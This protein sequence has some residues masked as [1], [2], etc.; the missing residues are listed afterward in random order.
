MISLK[1]CCARLLFTFSSLIL[2]AACGRAGSEDTAPALPDADA[3][4]AEL[5]QSADIVTTELTVRKLAI[6][7][8]EKSEPFTWTQPRTW[9]YGEQKCIIPVE[10]RIK[11]GYDLH[12]LSIDDIRL[13]PDSSS[14]VITLPAPKIIDASYNTYIDRGSVVGMSSG[15]RS[16]IG[17]AL[18]EEIRRKGYEAVLAEDL[19]PTVGRDIEQNAR[20]LFTSIVKRMGWKN[21]VIITRNRHDGRRASRRTSSSLA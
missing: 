5:Q 21:V 4:V 18:E 6:Y 9:K 7:D 11:Y 15:L 3:V 16:R 1:T 19:T 12:A 17:H 10:V 20:T 8:T 2:L 14:A 13:S